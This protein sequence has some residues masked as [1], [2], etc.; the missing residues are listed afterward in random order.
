MLVLEME[1]MLRVRLLVGVV[2]FHLKTL[3]TE[4]ALLLPIVLIRNL[5]FHCHVQRKEN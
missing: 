3:E 1:E 5:L 4:T 2:V